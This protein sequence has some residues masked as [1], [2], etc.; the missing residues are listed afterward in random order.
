M[1]PKTLHDV[2]LR[3]WDAFVA[4]G[5]RGMMLAHNELNGIQMHANHAIMTEHFRGELGYEGFFASDAGNVQALVG[6][7]V[8]FNG[9]DAA[10]IALQ[11]G[12]DQTMGG[13]LAPSITLPGVKSGEIDAAWIERAC[14]KVLTQKFAGTYTLSLLR[15]LPLP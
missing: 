11:A 3:P 8:A 7:R 5:G 4:A 14:A 9:T 6:A 15:R 12:M 13:G 2:Y 1:S 10:A